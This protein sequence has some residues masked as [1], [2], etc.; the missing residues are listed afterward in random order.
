MRK[1]MEQILL[2]DGELFTAA[3]GISMLPCIRP[4]KDILHLIRPEGT[5]ETS[6]VILYRRMDLIFFIELSE[7]IQK[8]LSS[9]G[10]I[11]GYRSMEFRRNKCLECCEDFTGERIM[12]I[13]E[14]IGDIGSM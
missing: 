10:I 14:R 12:S 3:S 8:G 7:K 2:E 6:E 4:Q 5:V 11:S 1:K 13:A 9:V